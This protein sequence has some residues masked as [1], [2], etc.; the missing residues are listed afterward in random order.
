VEDFDMKKKIVVLFI[1]CALTLSLVGC[2][3]SYEEATQESKKDY[4]DGYFTVV[5][6]WGGNMGYEYRIVYANDT[7]VKYLIIA[8]GHQY[9]V[10]PLYN[11]DGTLQ[12]YDGE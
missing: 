10:T 3:K 7:R 12:I 5:T 4:G 11:A 1:M 8:G 6:E 9:G 2:T